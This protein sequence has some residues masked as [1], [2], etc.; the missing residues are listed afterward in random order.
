LVTDKLSEKVAELKAD[1]NELKVQ[2]D[3]GKRTRGHLAALY[4]VANVLS[5][6]TSSAT[7][8]RAM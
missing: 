8:C 3:E 5:C 4:G 1:E 7:S 2:F 6:C